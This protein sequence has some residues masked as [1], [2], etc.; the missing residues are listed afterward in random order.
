MAEEPKVTQSRA[1]RAAKENRRS[2]ADTLTATAHKEASAQKGAAG[3]SA[4]RAFWEKAGQ[5]AEKP[6][7]GTSILILYPSIC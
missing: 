6:R 1:A 5:P 7:A 3:V 2:S 4:M